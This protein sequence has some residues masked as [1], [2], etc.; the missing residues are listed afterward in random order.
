[1]RMQKPCSCGT[2]ASWMAC[3]AP[4]TQAGVPH[5]LLRLI[6]LWHEPSSLPYHQCSD[7]GTLHKRPG[8]PCVPRSGQAQHLSYVGEICNNTPCHVADGEQ[9]NARLE[10]QLWLLGG[11]VQSSREAQNAALR[12]LPDLVHLLDAGMDHLPLMV[13]RS[14][15][16]G[17]VRF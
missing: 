15:L 2:P 7:S 12:C 17:F 8:N 14:M 3:S 9:H 1:M 11:L 4:C 16:Y 6:S 10:C 5:Q 13:F